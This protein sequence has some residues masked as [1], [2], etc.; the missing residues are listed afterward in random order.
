MR[1]KEMRHIVIKKRETRHP[2]VFPVRRKVD[3]TP[4]SGDSFDIINN[5]A[6]VISI[7]VVY[8]PP[9]EGK[10]SWIRKAVEVIKNAFKW[11]VPNK[12]TETIGEMPATEGR[13]EK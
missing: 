7:N 8:K 11:G 3:F 9:K 4:R 6:Y 12:E 13:T 1:C 10:M 5:I 2:S